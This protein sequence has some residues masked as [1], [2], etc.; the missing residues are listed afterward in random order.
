MDNEELFMNS[1]EGLLSLWANED[2]ATKSSCKDIK[3]INDSHSHSNNI[4]YVLDELLMNK[5]SQ[6]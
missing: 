5:V 3:I 6:T 1:G 4:S 2:M